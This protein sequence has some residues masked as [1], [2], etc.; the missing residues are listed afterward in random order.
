M[1]EYEKTYNHI[2]SIVKKLADNGTT[3]VIASQP[4]RY[5]SDGMPEPRLSM[6]AN[7]YLFVIDYDT[8]FR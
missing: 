5:N 6:P 8:S 7:E 2:K 3:F 4:L 1:S